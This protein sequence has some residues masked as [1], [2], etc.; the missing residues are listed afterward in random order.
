VLLRRF[1]GV[2]DKTYQLVYTENGKKLMTKLRANRDAIEKAKTRL[3]GEGAFMTAAERLQKQREAYAERQ[4]RQAEQR[5]ERDLPRDDR[6]G[7][8]DMMPP[9][10]VLPPGMR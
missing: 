4:R 7:P 5:G 1:G 8:D 9:D 2:A 10:M 6:Y 3:L